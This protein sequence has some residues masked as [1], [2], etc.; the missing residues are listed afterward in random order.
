MKRGVRIFAVSLGVASLILAVAA[1]VLVWWAKS[2]TALQ[3]AV[4]KIVATSGGR[5]SITGVHGSLAGNLVLDRILYK[6]PDI[7]VQFTNVAVD[8]RPHALLSRRV[9]IA[10]LSADT[11]EITPLPSSAPAALPDSLALPVAVGIDRLRVAKLV[12]HSGATPY[13][14]S[15]IEAGY[16]SDAVQHA[17][18]S[19]V[20]QSDFGS[21]NGNLILAATKPFA[22]GGSLDWGFG[23]SAAQAS[24]HTRVGGTLNRITA[25]LK[26]G[27]GAVPLHGSAVLALF[28]NNWLP[29]IVLAIRDADLAAVS[30][31]LP[32]TALF[33]TLKGG[34]DTKGRLSASLTLNNTA[35]GP[36]TDKRLPVTSLAMRI[37]A[38]EV[39]ASIN[40]LRASLGA[41]GKVSGNGR[42]TST[43]TE[44]DLTLADFNLRAI[45][46]PLR[47]T[48]LVGRVKAA[49]TGG[50]QTFE[51]ALTERGLTFAA[52]GTKQGDRIEV[53][54]LKAKAGKGEFTGKGDL[55]LAG[56]KLFRA[57]ARFTHFDPSDFGDF[58]GASISGEANATGQLAPTWH[59]EA[60]F[61]I[62]DS[63]FRSA[64]LAGSGT[65]KASARDIRDATVDLR[66]GANRL[67]ARGSFGAAGDA[68][69][70]E[71]DGQRLTQLDSRLAGKLAANGKLGGTIE[72]PTLVFNARGEALAFEKHLEVAA[73]EARGEWSSEADPR[74]N[75]TA[76]GRKVAV[77]TMRIESFA[78]SMNG[79]FGSHA[80][81]IGATAPEADFSVR[82]EGGLRAKRDWTGRVMSLTNR[83]RLPFALRA[84]VSLE[85]GPAR[86]AVGE[87]TVDAIGGRL[88]LR[89]L[90][91]EN[92]RLTSEGSFTGMP[93]AVLLALGGAGTMPD[94]NLTLRGSWAINATPQ[95]NGVLTI[96][97]EAGDLI[98]RQEPALPLGLE[99]LELDMKFTDDAS[100]TVLAVR[101]KQIGDI[102]AEVTAVPP[103][104]AGPFAPQSTLTGNARLDIATLRSLNDW[105]GTAALVD[106]AARL[107]LALAGTLA[108]PLLTGT[109]DGDRI[110]VE[111]PQHGVVLKD[112]RLRAELTEHALM[113]KG[114]S[115]AGPSGTL[116]ATGTLARRKTKGESQIKWQADALRLFDRPNQRLT[117][118]GGGT[119]DLLNDRLRMRGQLKVLNG[120]IE[121]ERPTTIRLSDDVVVV[122]RKAKPVPGVRRRPPIDLDAAFDFGEHF[123]IIGAG[124]E[125]GLQGNLRIHTSPDGTLLAAGRVRAVNGTYFAFAQKLTI[126]RGQLYFDGPIDNP[127]LEIVAVRKNLPVEAGVEVTG[128]VRIPR[129]RLIS[130]PPVPDNEKLAWL[131]TGRS[132]DN[133]SG[134][135]T[136]LL[137]AAASTFVNSKESIPLTR[138]IARQVGLDDIG[139]RSSGS[140]SG[141]L[142][143]QMLVVGKRLSDDLY[144]EY[145]HS[146]DIASTVLR[147]TYQLTRTLSLRVES[148]TSSTFGLFFR[149]SFD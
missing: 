94:S 49:L 102:A 37:S 145:E 23:E 85:A 116:A 132:L 33:G 97:R 90:R 2:E 117:V 133:A 11:V 71:F 139:M 79:T 8:W 50:R 91:W 95:L 106:G 147:L 39:G 84:P 40:E 24:A 93:A 26:G 148:G 78:A 76:A 136:A 47:A 22:I 110:S 108:A 58:P 146:L 5:V 104:G 135:D 119:V 3:W 31:T 124:L 64:P 122:G 16:A 42:V 70:F 63:K 131:V 67:Q 46:R 10:T 52:S 130:E 88:S 103:A 73:L 68:L 54:N 20:L 77:S 126:E 57:N 86:A 12:V 1:G 112:G 100:R 105:L 89:S 32:S 92:R 81:S 36:W 62:K 14:L 149:R 51:A 7:E 34:T 6:T 66:V 138:R 109:L 101:G 121:F 74:F 48:K 142:D 61:T 25:D 41:G 43:G 127:G 111:V 9:N 19:L 120:H 134:A 123:K 55:S 45:H 59:A 129:V 115:I 107:R 18:T 72:R 28:A 65:F 69:D 60:R 27:S 75:L 144:L 128:T 96:T 125:S 118:A 56:V 143:S 113:L 87:A 17:I 82:L 53:H 21:V 140:S 13:A 38:T 80:I 99:R 44:W 15:G 35:A 98:V 30:T 137:Q 141:S 29:E 4:S 83:G 114:F